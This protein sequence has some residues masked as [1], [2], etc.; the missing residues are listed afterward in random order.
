MDRIYAAHT[1]LTAPPLPVSPGTGFPRGG[2]IGVSP[3][4]AGPYWFHMI[5]ESLRN[6]ILE[7]GLTPDAADLTLLDDAIRTIATAAAAAA[8]SDIPPP[9][10]A[11]GFP[12]RAWVNFH[13]IGATGDFMTIRA[14]GNVTSVQKVDTG[15]YKITFTTAMPTP[16][17]AVS[18]GFSSYGN[19]TATVKISGDSAGPEY[20]PENMTTAELTI[21]TASGGAVVDFGTVTAMVVC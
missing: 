4:Q 6:V 12:C 8:V 5:T 11:V 10:A 16:H 20:T 3:T 9:P 1:A 19:N 13:G 7:A 15:K 21:Q 14:S 17:Y 18:L 2:D